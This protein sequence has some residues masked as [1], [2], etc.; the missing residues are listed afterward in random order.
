MVASPA[1]RIALVNGATS[2]EVFWQVGSSATIGTYSD[3]AGHIMADQ[4]ITMA[5]GASLDGSALAEN[6]A[7]TFDHNNITISVVPEPGSA[8]LIGSGLAILLACRRKF[9]RAAQ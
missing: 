6:A 4:S 2:S 1:A 5:T 3:F 7:V 9:S 8:L